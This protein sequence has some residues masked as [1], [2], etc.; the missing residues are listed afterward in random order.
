MTRL[1][2]RRGVF[3]QLSYLIAGFAG[4][5]AAACGDHL[6]EGVVGSCCHETWADAVLHYF[7]ACVLCFE[8]WL[9]VPQV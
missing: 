1:L 9:L 5:V 4:I 3:R 2:F 7:N 6:P 8:V